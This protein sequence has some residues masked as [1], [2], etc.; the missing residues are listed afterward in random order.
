MDEVR[1]AMPSRQINPLSFFSKLFWL[2]G[3]PLTVEPYRQKI[4]RDVL[5]NFTYDGR[6]RYSLALCLRGKKNNKSLDLIPASLYFL[7]CRKCIS[8]S[9]VLNVAFDENQAA[10]DLSYR[11]AEI[12]G[13]E[14]LT[15]FNPPERAPD[16]GR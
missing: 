14:E 9:T 6:L 11:P 15:V 3:R 4:F 8:G 1:F 16:L 13:L 5:F 10:Q 2:D 12:E 7:L